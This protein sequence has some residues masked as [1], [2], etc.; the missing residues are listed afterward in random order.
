MAPI[1]VRACLGCHNDQKSDSGLNLATFA[2]LRAGGKGAGTAILEPGDPDAS[3]LVEVVRPDASPRMPYKKPPLADSQITLLERWVREGAKF[4]GPSEGE[5]RLA[6]LVDPLVGLPEVAVTVPVSDPAAAAAYSPDGITLAVAVG[7]RVELTHPPATEPFRTLTDAPGPI[8]ALR[9]TPDGGRLVAAGGRPGSF[10]A[11]TVWEL[12]RASVVHNLR[13]H[14]DAIL[15]ADL[16]P[17]GRT[18]AT[19]SYDRLILLWDLE[20]G[21]STR[22]LK[23]HTDAV[24]AVAFAPD[25]RTLA[26]AGADR[27]VKLWDVAT[28][29]RRVTLSDPTAEQYAVAFAPDGSVVYAAG[30]DRSIRA[31]DARA[32]NTPLLRSAFAHDAAVLRLVPAPD[33]RTLYSAGEDRA[34]K[35]WDLPDLRPRSDLPAQSDWPLALAVRSDGRQLVVGRYDGSAA[36]FDPTKPSDVIEVRA[37]PSAAAE[38][39]PA[40]TP[41]LVRSPSLNPPSPRGAARGTTVR[42][43]L[44]GNEVG[45]ATALLFDEPGLTATIVPAAKP[46]PNRLEVDLAIAA[47]ARPG[48]HRLGVQTALGVPASQPFA[49]SAH[50]EV[51]LAEPDD[52]PKA[53]KPVELPATLVGTIERPGDLDHVAVPFRAGQTLVFELLA[54]GIGSTLSPRLEL[55]DGSGRV[56][57]SGSAAAGSGEESVLTYTAPAEATLTLRV[58]DAEYGGSGGHLYRI[59]AGALPRV[60]AAFPLGVERG[61][62]AS[63]A[64]EGENLGEASTATVKGDAPAGTILGVPVEGPDAPLAGRAP[65]VVVA[66]GPQGVEAEPNDSVGQ[67][68]ALAVPGG[69]SGRL[70]RDGDVDFVRF[71]AKA[72][73]TLIL[74]VFAR[75]LGTPVDPVVE[76]VDAE[77]RPVPRAVVRPVSETVVAFRDHDSSSPRIRLTQWN[78]LAVNDVVLVGRELI[79]VLALPKNPDD[80]C[81]FWNAQGR[82][83]GLLETTPE[84]HPMGQPIYKVE[85]HPPG[86]T[87]PAGGVPPV[88]LTYRNDDGGPGMGKDSRLTFTPPADGPY[89]ARVEDVR[90][91]G[92]PH[93]AYHLLIR[94]PRPD[95][96][97]E[98][99]TADPNVPRG[100]AA[101]LTASVTR[102]DGFDGPVEVEL[103]D[104][105]PG[106]TATT[107]RIEP[108]QTAADLLLMADASAPAYTQPTWRAVARAV[109]PGPELERPLEPGGPSGG[110]ITVVPA[111]DL[112]I[113][114]TPERVEIRAGERVEMTLAV[115]RAAGFEGRVPIDVRNLPHG[116]R[117]LYIG[118]NGV[119][120]TE[121]DRAR[122]IFLYAEP[123]VEPTER[124]FYAEGR[125][126]LL[127]EAKNGLGRPVTATSRPASSPPIRLVVQPAPKP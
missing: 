10:G 11:V 33:G 53:A 90:G 113:S 119:L 118:L 38:Q 79:R 57:A 24:H 54:R 115:E 1:L 50:P 125:L 76:V 22:T 47:D 52:D 36:L 74:E 45:R 92:G 26:S 28:G 73:E 111:S 112:A 13:G 110:R 96:Q 2:G 59:A 123:W 94:R 106:I 44:S 103:R 14:A 55:L 51:A 40:K 122:S 49:V 58:A 18:L 127:G 56:V 69:L 89:F 99:S 100:G 65:T 12:E 67:A 34:I 126:Q 78:D 3:H 9:F 43:T 91:L 7:G 72:G 30:V 39:A 101:I 37:A 8:T 17:D 4:D 70:D 32:A 46:D 83:L 42:V 31:W 61:R 19:A 29:A 80:D 68:P 120:V 86:T 48:V 66:D 85:L 107:A 117:V 20:A 124:L 6:T 16:A 121:T 82:R 63:I 77:G 21:R 105:P 62:S 97:A 75:R 84:Q 41:E 108:G 102:L 71:E 114:A 109:G 15:A 81:L 64:L 116:V 93:H 5:T 88:T 87:F 27:T 95:F 25:G 23:E 98:L 104:L 35:V 60:A